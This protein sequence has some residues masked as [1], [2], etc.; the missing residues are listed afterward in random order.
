MTIGAEALTATGESSAKNVQFVSTVAQ[1]TSASH[2]VKMETS[3]RM[4]ALRVVAKAASAAAGKGRANTG[5]RTT[6]TG[7]V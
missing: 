5:V 7:K 6:I 3:V 2:I 1:Q 4:F